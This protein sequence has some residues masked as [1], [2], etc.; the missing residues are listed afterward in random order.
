MEHHPCGAASIQD[1][2]FIADQNTIPAD[3]LALLPKTGA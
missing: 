2:E 3:L 1:Q